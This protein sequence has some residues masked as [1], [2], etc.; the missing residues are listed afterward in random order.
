MKTY[1]KLKNSITDRKAFAKHIGCMIVGNECES[2]PY[3]ANNNDDTNWIV[4]LSNDWRVGFTNEKLNVF[5]ISYRYNSELNDQEKPL[6]SWLC[7]RLNAKLVIDINEYL[8]RNT[9]LSIA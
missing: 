9:M 2:I 4:D 1:I 7:A 5:Y 3:M 8:T 6:S